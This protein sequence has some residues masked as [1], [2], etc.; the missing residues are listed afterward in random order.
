MEWPAAHG[1]PEILSQQNQDKIRVDESIAEMITLHRAI[2]VF[3]AAPA[4]T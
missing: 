2:A 4:L 1:W 3:C